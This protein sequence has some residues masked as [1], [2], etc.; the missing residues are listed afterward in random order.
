MRLVI[1][2]AMFIA[3]IGVPS[4]HA[5]SFSQT[6]LFAP[7]VVVEPV[8][9]E[10][11]LPF[12]YMGSIAQFDPAI[13]TLVSVVLDLDFDMRLQLNLGPAGGASG[14]SV[15]GQVYVNNLETAFT[16]GGNGGGGGG[17]PSMTVEI[18]VPQSYLQTAVVGGTENSDPQA[19]EF[20]GTGDVLI[21]FRGSVFV[22]P[23]AGATMGGVIGGGF[24]S[25][26]V[27]TYDFVSPFA[28]GDYNGDGLVDAADYTVWRDNLASNAQ[29]PG[30]ITPGVVDQ[31]DYVVWR[32]AF[33]TEGSILGSLANSMVPE[34][35]TLLL[36]GGLLLV[37]AGLV[38]RFRRA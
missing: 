2:V 33:G 12:N 29:L 17:G 7:G 31:S 24:P 38:Q 9:A 16:G 8:S 25:T 35:Q 3:L 22:Q 5:V 1:L 36:A 11:T 21:D 13:G 20:I 30:D 19:V 34:P 32:T 18:P 14:G 15:F 28:A 37:G 4:A 10:A 6:L 27:V 23:P 26:I